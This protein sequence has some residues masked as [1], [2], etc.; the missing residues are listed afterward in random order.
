MMG[1]IFLLLIVGVIIAIWIIKTYN[2]LQALMQEIREGYAN[3]QAT[4]KKREQLNGQMIDIASKYLPKMLSK[5]E[6]REVIL[7]L[8]DKSI[9]NVMKH[10]KA[11]Y[12][13]KCDMRL[14]QEVLKEI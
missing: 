14:V 5:E 9:P 11:N 8:D 12:N 2:N 6:I 4:L 3:L 1:F 10:F 13:G 7:S